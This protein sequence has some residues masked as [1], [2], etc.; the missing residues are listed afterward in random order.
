M[1]NDLLYG[2]YV[3]V[4]FNEDVKECAKGTIKEIM[5]IPMLG[6]TFKPGKKPDGKFIDTKGTPDKRIMVMGVYDYQKK[7]MDEFYAV[8]D[9][10]DRVHELFQSTPKLQSEII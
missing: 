10:I 8:I 4:T 5:V 2:N 9:S 1:I 7:I 6:K 3:N